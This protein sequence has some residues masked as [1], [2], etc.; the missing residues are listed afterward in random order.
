[1]RVRGTITLSTTRPK[2]VELKSPHPKHPPVPHYCLFIRLAAPPIHSAPSKT[3]RQIPT[4]SENRMRL[5]VVD[6]PNPVTRL[7]VAKNQPRDDNQ[8]GVSHNPTPLPTPPP[9]RSRQP[10]SAMTFSAA[11]ELARYKLDAIFTDNTV[12]HHPSTRL[13]PPGM[14]NTTT[15]WNS[16]KVLGS[17]TFGTVWLQNEAG[18][19]HLRA[20]KIISKAQSDTQELQTLVNLR[21]VS[22]PRALY[23]A[24]VD[25]AA[26]VRTI[27]SSSSR[28]SKTRVRSS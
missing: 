24:N 28:G 18:T 3:N 15:V 19:G 21:D 26:S 25:A 12:T 7:G 10:S 17:G 11:P 4:A 23:V 2:A 8:C 22:R 14:A 5:R 27:S 6:L 13:P 16:D 9:H 20:V 1:M